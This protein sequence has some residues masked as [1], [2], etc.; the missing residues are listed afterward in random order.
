MIISSLNTVNTFLNLHS[1]ARSV[2]RFKLQNDMFIKSTSFTGKQKDN[3]D[4]KSF[5]AFE[6]WAEETDFL[7]KVYDIVHY[8]GPIL[9]SGFEGE[10]YGIPGN[11][12]W[13]VKKFKKG[14]FVQKYTEKPTIIKHDDISPKLNI[15]QFICRVEIPS[16]PR[17]TNLFYILKK[18]KG[19]SLGVSYNY[20]DKIDDDNNKIHIRTLKELSEAPDRTFEKCIKDIKYISSL[21]FEFDSGNPYNFMFDTDKQEINFVDINDKYTGSGTQYG[22]VLY[23]L[24]DSRYGLLFES[25]EKTP[26]KDAEKFKNKLIDKFFKAMKKENVK[27]TEGMYFTKLLDSTTL[28]SY[29]KTSSREE[30]VKKLKQLKLM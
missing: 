18:Q 9:G 17:F 23:A 20:S 15:G 25:S 2:N 28:D 4:D 26:K 14:D 24:L 30:K 21:G 8:T 7:S 1:E 12:Q 13:V 11:E 16:G 22:E 10:T 27:L 5:E 3:I 29:L 6:K 19:H